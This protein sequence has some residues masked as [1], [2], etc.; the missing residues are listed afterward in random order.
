MGVPEFME[1]L[2]QAGYRS[3]TLAEVPGL[4]VLDPLPGGFIFSNSTFEPSA[5][6][7]A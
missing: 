3:I 4:T 6:S 1:V 7:T 5:A 2:K